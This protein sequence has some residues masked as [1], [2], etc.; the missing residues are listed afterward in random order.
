MSSLA[1]C[2]HP[3][4][5]SSSRNLRPFGPWCA[6]GCAVQIKHTA[7]ATKEALI[8]CRD[9]DRPPRLNPPGFE[10]TTTLKAPTR[11]SNA[12]GA[13]PLPTFPGHLRRQGRVAV[14]SSAGAVADPDEVVPV[15]TIRVAFLSAPAWG[16][17]MPRR[18]TPFPAPARRTVR[19]VLP[20]TAHRRLSPAVFGD[21]SPPGP[22]GPGATTIPFRL[23]GL[24]QGQ[25]WTGNRGLSVGRPTAVPRLPIDS[26]DR[27][28]S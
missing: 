21:E 14:G 12:E 18:A 23:T 10:L 8:R 24:Q 28:A 5:A 2:R 17:Q 19:A 4:C 11:E 13:A 25:G 3:R 26:Q 15:Q 7:G 27:C 16:P 6:Q 20:H 9:R 1:A 22:V